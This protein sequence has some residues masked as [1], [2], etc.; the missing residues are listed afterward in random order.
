MGWSKREGRYVSDK[1]E[2]RVTQ[3]EVDRMSLR[4]LQIDQKTINGK[5]IDVNY[6]Y[7]LWISGFVTGDKIL[8]TLDH[9]LDIIE[10][11]TDLDKSNVK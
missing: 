9:L 6:I 3:Q 8:E 4:L 7:K 1:D 2:V 10:Q 5:E 11:H